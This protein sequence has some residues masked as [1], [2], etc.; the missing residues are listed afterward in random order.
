MIQKRNE[1]QDFCLIDTPPERRLSA[2][3]RLTLTGGE[4]LE[5]AFHWIARQFTKITESSLRG[6]I[7]IP[8]LK[9]AA[10]FYSRWKDS[11]ASVFVPPPPPHAV[12]ESAVHGL[13]DG[14]ILDLSFESAY[15][16][17]CEEFKATA[18]KFPENRSVYARWWKH[19]AVP[20]ATIVAV[21]AWSMG[22]QRVNS[23]A[24]VPGYFFKRGFDVVLIE[25]PYHGRRAPTGGESGAL[26]FPDTD[27]TR[28]NEAMGQSIS[29][30]RQLAD[31]LRSK[32]RTSIGCVG[33]S[34]GA[35]L[36]ALWASL[37]KLEFCISVVPF[38]SMADFAW[39]LV[40]RE[41]QTLA[42][43]SKGGI[44]R[45]LLR[46]TFAL[47][48]PLSHQPKLP[49]DRMLILAG[50]ADDVVPRA[51]TRR[52]WEHWGRPKMRW[53]RGGHA[54][55]FKKSDAFKEIDSFLRQATR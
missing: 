1:P 16:P 15:V 45:A 28:T 53:F 4:E 23:L 50:L 21:H 33:V 2:L 8:H 11:P 24:F 3:E 47:H 26:L 27:P 48:S 19:H 14:E 43:L 22:D 30:L 49:R 17:Q 55:H 18:E 10:E 40:R 44:T 12:I 54:A 51:H 6:N 13:R 25:L 34:L 35:Y 29:D 5:R 41:K 36:G 46:D 20:R 37:D 39:D 52:L 9:S 42:A 38:V 31:Y 32:G 7:D